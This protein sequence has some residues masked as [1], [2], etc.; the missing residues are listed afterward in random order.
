MMRADR[1]LLQGALTNLVLNAQDAMPEGGTLTIRTVLRGENILLEVADTGEGMTAEECAR[2]FTPYYTTRQY[3]TGLG[4]AMVQSV[5][6][7][8]GGKISVASEPGRGS[9]FRIELPL[10]ADETERSQTEEEPMVT[11]S[12]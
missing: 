12:R 5:V 11:E 8:H 1:D 7:D 10:R 2:L 4:L 6:S 3:G 9:A